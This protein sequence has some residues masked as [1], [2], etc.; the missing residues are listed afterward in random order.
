M[1]R[2]LKKACSSPP[3]MQNH[4][5]HSFT[6]EAYFAPPHTLTHTSA[7]VEDA[8]QNQGV[9]VVR[10]EG[11]LMDKES[12][13]HTMFKA[14]RHRAPHIGITHRKPLRTAKA[15]DPKELLMVLA[16]SVGSSKGHYQRIRRL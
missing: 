2:L 11:G 12:K 5:A 4:E 9:S 3:S 14:G 1:S 13:V 15:T 8:F 6:F 10:H 7:R 16:P